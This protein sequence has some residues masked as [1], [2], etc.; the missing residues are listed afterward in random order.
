[1]TVM[2]IALGSGSS[3]S[4]FPAG[5]AARFIN[6]YVERQGDDSKSPEIAVASDGLTSFA[7]LATYPVRAMLEVGAYFYVVSG[8]VFYQ[9]DSSGN[10]VVLGN[11]P[12][13]GLVTMV[14]NRQIGRAHV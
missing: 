9:V 7:T 1:M 2:P 14:R 10:S 6:C 3:P 4:R 11:V 12:T 5:G 13:D 8:R